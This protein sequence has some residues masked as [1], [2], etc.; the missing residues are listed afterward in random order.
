LEEEG[1]GERSRGQ[2]RAPTR[3]REGKRRRP[4]RP[5]FPSSTRC[6]PSLARALP[7]LLLRSFFRS[8]GFL[9]KPYVRACLAIGNRKKRSAVARRRGDASLSSCS[10]IQSRRLPSE[11]SSPLPPRETSPAP[12]RGQ[13]ARNRGMTGLRTP[14]VTE[15]ATKI[16]AEG[17]CAES[18]KGGSVRRK[19][20]REK[21]I[22]RTRSLFSPSIFGAQTLALRLLHFDCFVSFLSRPHSLS[23]SL[24]VSLFL[25]LSVR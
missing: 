23:F 1:R 22:D 2:E 3:S 24:C 4:P 11:T 14:M 15:L 20:G 21:N 6:R 10:K 5:P 16:Q 12:A 13:P 9:A 17:L 18:R 25:S 8:D 7:A 19:R